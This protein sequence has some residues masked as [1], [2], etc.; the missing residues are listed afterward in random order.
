[1]VPLK[2]NTI[3][4][5]RR[6]PYRWPTN[7]QRR[8]VT[9]QN[10]RPHLSDS[11]IRWFIIKRRPDAPFEHNAFLRA[12]VRSLVSTYACAKWSFRGDLFLISIF[13]LETSKSLIS[14]IVVHFCRFC[15]TVFHFAPRKHQQKTENGCRKSINEHRCRRTSPIS[16][17]RQ[18]RR[19]GHPGQQPVLG[20]Y[21]WNRLLDRSQF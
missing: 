14:R 8:T 19:K 11:N 3:S 1:M 2:S 18:I 21:N 5:S 10:T 6:P 7:N 17:G 4:I 15:F 9:P 13:P 20:E 12:T 16:Q